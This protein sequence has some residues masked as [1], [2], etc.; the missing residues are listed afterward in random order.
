MKKKTRKF[1][2]CLNKIKKEQKLFKKIL[3]K[4]T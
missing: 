4:K 3:Q 1:R 2:C